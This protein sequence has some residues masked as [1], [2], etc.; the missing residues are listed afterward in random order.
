M[1][2]GSVSTQA[3]SAG[4][5]IETEFWSSAEVLAIFESRHA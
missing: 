3:I 2:T 5:C 4:C 1:D